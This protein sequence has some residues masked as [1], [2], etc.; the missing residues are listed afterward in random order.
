MEGLLL[1]KGPRRGLHVITQQLFVYK[2]R[3][4]EGDRY[5]SN[6]VPTTSTVFETDYAVRGYWLSGLK[7]AFE[8]VEADLMVLILEFAGFPICCDQSVFFV[9]L[10]CFSFRVNLDL[11]EDV[12]GILQ[13]EGDIPDS[14]LRRAFK[15][16]DFSREVHSRFQWVK[17][18][19]S[20]QGMLN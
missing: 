2:R 17:T 15:M 6:I 5:G 14:V 18:V 13:N 4:I 10:D 7:S 16:E 9:I 3:E 1:W 19:M 8:N 20:D 12:Q 11:D